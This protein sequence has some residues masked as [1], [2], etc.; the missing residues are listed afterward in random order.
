MTRGAHRERSSPVQGRRTGRPRRPGRPVRPA[1]LPLRHAARRRG[2]LGRAARARAAPPPPPRAPARRRHCVGAPRG[3]RRA[4]HRREADPGRRAPRARGGR[5]RPR[6]PRRSG[7]VPRR[8]RA[9]ATPDLGGAARPGRHDERHD[10]K[11][12]RA[13]PLRGLPGR[14]GAR[15][16]GPL[17]RPGHRGVQ[18][19]PRQ[20]PH[21][22]VRDAAGRSARA[23]ARVAV[24]APRRPRLALP[25]RRAPRFPDERARPARARGPCVVDV[26]AKIRQGAA[27]PRDCRSRHLRH[28]DERDG[29]RC[30]RPREPGQLPTCVVAVGAARGREPVRRAAPRRGPEAERAALPGA[31]LDGGGREADSGAPLDGGARR[32]RG[33]EAARLGGA[34]RD[35]VDRSHGRRHEQRGRE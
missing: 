31:R 24:H 4:E 28:R 25:A 10:P 32:C 35:G 11:G 12:V 14:S 18:P 13:D 5:A 8:D 6:D 26:L 22:A 33:G 20:V 30:G 19:P 27:A 1:P 9:R 2:L 23:P 34:L 16:L 7:P 17:R 29:V 15:D 3:A 21:R